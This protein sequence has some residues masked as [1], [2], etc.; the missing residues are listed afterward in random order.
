[1]INVRELAGSARFGDWR[2]IALDPLARR[3]ICRCAHCSTT[4]QASLEALKR[5]EVRPCD[6]HVLGLTGQGFERAKADRERYRRSRG[7][8]VRI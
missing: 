4:I 6:R 1:M 5:G 8:R 7:L 2:V 3:A